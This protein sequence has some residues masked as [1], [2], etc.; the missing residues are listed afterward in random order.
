MLKFVFAEIFE[1]L[2]AKE[3]VI[4]LHDRIQDDIQTIFRQIACFNFE[5]ELHRAIRAKGSLSKEEI[6]ALLNKHMSAYLG[7]RFKM[8]ELDGYFFVNWSHIRRFFYVYS[9]AYGQLISKAFH[10]KLEKDSHFIEKVDD[11]LRAGESKSP[12]DIFK[13][14]GLDTRKPDIF[15][16]GLASIEKDVA[17]LERL[18]K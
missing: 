14:C 3:K 6:G 1:T 18:V 2:S 7:P 12:Y 13:S 4:A 10:R 15:L 16:E 8:T 17:T 5:T 11:F 9:Y